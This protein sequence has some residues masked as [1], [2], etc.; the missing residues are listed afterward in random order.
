MFKFYLNGSVQEGL[1]VQDCFYSLVATFNPGSMSATDLAKQLETSG[2]L[3]L[4]TVGKK[5]CRVWI[6]L[7]AND[8]LFAQFDW[9]RL[10]T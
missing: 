4:V 7:S 1:S 5:D 9:V 2:S 3:A 10:L 6:P 8:L